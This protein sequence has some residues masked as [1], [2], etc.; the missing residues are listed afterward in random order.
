[1]SKLARPEFRSMPRRRAAV[2]CLAHSV[3]INRHMNISVEKDFL[4]VSSA[5]FGRLRFRAL[6]RAWYM[7]L[8]FE[9]EAVR[10]ERAQRPLAPDIPVTTRDATAHVHMC[11]CRVHFVT[12]VG[13][14]GDGPG[15]VERLVRRAFRLRTLLAGRMRSSSWPRGAVA[16]SQ[17]PSR[18]VR[19]ASTLYN[20]AL[21]WSCGD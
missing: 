18:S 7:C 19:S 4:A 2:S 15:H 16:F 9:Y 6:W 3:P 11:V 13:K 8:K 21:L 17:L 12:V 5:R 1:M 20:S 14:D 10:V